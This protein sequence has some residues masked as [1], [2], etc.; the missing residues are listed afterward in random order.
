MCQMG[1]KRPETAVLKHQIFGSDPRK[2]SLVSAPSFPVLL[3]GERSRNL[4]CP[5]CLETTQEDA[6]QCSEQELSLA[7]PACSASRWSHLSPQAVLHR[8]LRPFG[9]PRNRYSSALVLTSR[10]DN[11]RLKQ[12]TELLAPSW[13]HVESTWRVIGQA[14]TLI[15]NQGMFLNAQKSA[16]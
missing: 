4:G 1:S 12:P 11:L 8:F 14:E 7:S 15:N 10:G 9:A 3:G 5:W 16:G 6:S 13:T 2:P